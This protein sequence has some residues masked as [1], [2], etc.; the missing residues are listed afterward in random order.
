MISNGGI[1][2]FSVAGLKRLYSIDT[3]DNKVAAVSSP[4]YGLKPS[5]LVDIVRIAISEENY[6]KAE[7]ALNVLAESG[8]D[9]AYQTAFVDYTNG[10]NGKV[11][12]ESACSMIVSSPSSTHQICG[13]TGLPLHKVSQDKHGN[14][15]P[16][17]RKG[18]DDTYEGKYFMNSKIFF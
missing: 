2:S 16:G 3:M 12:A 17:Y 14:C 4:V 6:S 11:I 15:I 8:D 5:E 9:R 18:M 7:D 10:L 13:H 1:E